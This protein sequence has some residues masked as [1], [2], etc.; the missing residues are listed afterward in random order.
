MGGLHRLKT[1]KLQ[2]GRGKEVNDVLKDFDELERT[3]LGLG[4]AIV[5]R[6][7]PVKYGGGESWRERR[8]RRRRGK[9]T[10]ER[11]TEE[12]LRWKAMAA[13]GAQRG[14]EREASFDGPRVPGLPRDLTLTESQK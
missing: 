14:K 8:R 6:R 12:T 10:R 3:G 11:K 9:G 1:W 4:N 5:A 2:N 13:A 7:Y